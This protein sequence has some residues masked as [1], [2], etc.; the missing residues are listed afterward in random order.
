MTDLNKK[1]E[2][3]FYKEVDLRLPK[4]VNYFT[5]LSGGIDSS[6]IASI[7]SKIS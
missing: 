5:A 1:F 2:D 7:A 3:I 6:L 4:E